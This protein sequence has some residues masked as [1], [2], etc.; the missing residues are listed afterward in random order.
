MFHLRSN[1]SCS[2]HLIY[3]QLLHFFTKLFRNIVVKG[4]RECVI[5]QGN[6]YTSKLIT[7]KS[8]D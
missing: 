1:V 3:P 2:Q 6:T 4:L 8:A 7:H 5:D